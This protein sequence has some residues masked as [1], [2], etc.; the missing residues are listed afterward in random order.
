[1]NILDPIFYRT[2]F[3][4]FRPVISPGSK[5]ENFWLQ[6]HREPANLG[7]WHRSKKKRADVHQHPRVQISI[8]KQV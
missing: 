2:L 7:G 8:I 4:D 1:M 5:V 3:Y 6:F